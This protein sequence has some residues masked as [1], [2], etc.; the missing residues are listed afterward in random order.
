[1][2]QTP[3][4]IAALDL[5]EESIQETW[6]KNLKAGLAHY[7]PRKKDLWQFMKEVQEKNGRIQTT[8]NGKTVNLDTG[9]IL[10]P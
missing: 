3:E 8:E 6:T 10:N 1:M 9:E 4:E 7:E 5:E 2:L